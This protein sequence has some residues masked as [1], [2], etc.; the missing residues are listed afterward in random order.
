MGAETVVTLA[1]VAVVVG[2]IAMYLIIIAATLTKV[3]KTLDVILNDVIHSVEHKTQG[4]GNTV[5]SIANE[6][7]AIEDAMAGLTARDRRGGR[8][9][10]RA[11]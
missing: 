1:I 10:A 6:V 11:Y 9:R 5:A 2:A 3:S 8:R 4:V 7:R